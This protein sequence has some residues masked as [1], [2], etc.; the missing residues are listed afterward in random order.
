[1]TQRRILAGS[2]VAAT[3][4]LT[5][6]LAQPQL[7]RTITARAQMDGGGEIP[8]LSRKVV[9][10]SGRLIGTFRETKQG[11]QFSWFLTYNGLSGKV[12]FAN[13]ESGT[14]KKRGGTI[15]FLCAPCTS[16]AHGSFYAS[17]GELTLL[18]K[19]HLYVNLR[20]KR[21]PSGEIRG[22]LVKRSA[23]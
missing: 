18:K 14:T 13:I 8:A 12:T 6:S 11:Y 5:P 9:K 4:L 2:L 3:A 16:G 1:M 22:R 21:H 7:S 10:G 23:R 19:N 15:A 20:T 17:P